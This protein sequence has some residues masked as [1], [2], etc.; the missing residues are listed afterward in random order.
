MNESTIK[1]LLI[2]LIERIII[3]KYPFLELHSIQGPSE[4]INPLATV[5]YTVF[6]TSIPLDYIMV[7]QIKHEVSNLFKSAGFSMYN[8]RNYHYGVRVEIADKKS[9]DIIEDL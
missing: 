1:S 9:G 8:F 3:P 6:T 7:K 4:S 5:F 2:S